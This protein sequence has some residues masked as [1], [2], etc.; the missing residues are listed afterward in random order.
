VVKAAVPA[1]ESTEGILWGS[2]FLARK[3]EGKRAKKKKTAAKQAKIADSDDTLTGDWQRER[4][5]N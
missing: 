2:W 1:F 5:K 3:C 4:W